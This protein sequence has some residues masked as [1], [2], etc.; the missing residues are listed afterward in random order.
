MLEE[1]LYHRGTTLVRRME[2]EQGEAT[3][4]HVDPFHRVSV[5][6][7]GGVLAIESRDGRPTI[8]VKVAPGQVDWDEP[9]HHIH[10]AVNIGDVPYEEI[11]GS[12]WPTPT[13]SRSRTLPNRRSTD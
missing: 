3:R 13:M 11:A 4:W 9:G 8:E 5:V 12:S 6:L 7:K 10:R 1:T 2:I